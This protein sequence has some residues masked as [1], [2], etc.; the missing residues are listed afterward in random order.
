VYTTHQAANAGAAHHF[1][2]LQS[3]HSDVHC[4]DSGGLL[5]LVAEG[6]REDDMVVYVEK[7]EVADEESSVTVDELTDAVKQAGK[8]A[9]DRAMEEQRKQE[10]EDGG[11]DSYG[12]P[13][14]QRSDAA[15]A[16]NRSK[17]TCCVTA[18]KRRAASKGRRKRK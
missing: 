7:H 13:M 9:R 2:G 3:S 8:E 11:Y 4:N 15:Q 12:N 1:I 5:Q 18:G 6:G 10:D 14:R 17:S 16:S